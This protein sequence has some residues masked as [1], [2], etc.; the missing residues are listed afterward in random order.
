MALIRADSDMRSSLSYDAR[1]FTTSRTWALSAAR[2]SSWRRSPAATRERTFTD[3]SV[4]CLPALS[5][6]GPGGIWFSPLVTSRVLLD[7]GVNYGLR[8][9]PRGIALQLVVHLNR[10]RDTPMSGPTAE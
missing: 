4:A 10:A 9:R 8:L 1:R 6:A 2:R 5:V 3:G 7:L